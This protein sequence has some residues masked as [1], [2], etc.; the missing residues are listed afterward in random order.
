M[1][2]GKVWPFRVLPVGSE[3]MLK[4]KDPQNLLRN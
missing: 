4:L 2:P 1:I 3:C